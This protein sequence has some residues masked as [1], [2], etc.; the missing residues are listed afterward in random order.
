MRIW[1]IAV[2]AMAAL[3]G[4]ATAQAPFVYRP[5][6]TGQ[7]IV[8]PTDAL[9]GAA[10][11]TTTGTIRTLSRTVAGAIESNGF[12]RTVN[13]LFGTRAS[14]TPVQAGFSPLPLPTSYQS[15]R[16]QNN[17]LPSMPIMSVYGRTPNVP[18]PPNAFG[19]R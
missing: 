12:V 1:G 15:T 11:T 3:A 14:A 19:G 2:A 7:L 5:I 16:Y 6:D 17:F 10:A 8:Q 18:V 4:T 13:N 9:T